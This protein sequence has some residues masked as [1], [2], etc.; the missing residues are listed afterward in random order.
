MADIAWASMQK[1]FVHIE[2]WFGVVKFGSKPIKF[3]LQPGNENEVKHQP[4]F[5][6]CVS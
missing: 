4:V 6:I 3:I 5:I 2:T 1:D